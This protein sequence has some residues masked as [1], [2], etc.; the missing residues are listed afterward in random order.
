M[1][2]R[3]RVWIWIHEDLPDDQGEV[4]EDE[5][6]VLPSEIH[7]WGCFLWGTLNTLAEETL[8]SEGRHIVVLTLVTLNDC[9][10]TEKNLF[11]L[12]CK[13]VIDGCGFISKSG[14]L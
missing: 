8:I 13:S 2:R 10:Q 7:Q 3:H 4:S 11:N 14:S 12:H 5:L 6:L 1:W 9:S